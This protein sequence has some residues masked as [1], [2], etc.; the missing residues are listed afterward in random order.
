MRAE[1]TCRSTSLSGDPP[2]RAT[3]AADHRLGVAFVSEEPVAAE[4]GEV[5]GIPARPC[6]AERVVADLGGAAVVTVTSIQKPQSSKMKALS[7]L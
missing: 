6:L 7:S 2:D 5:A 3:F 1:S 4:R